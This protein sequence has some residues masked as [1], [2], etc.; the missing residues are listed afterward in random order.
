MTKENPILDATSF[1]KRIIIIPSKIADKGTVFLR[2]TLHSL[3]P[4]P[5][6]VTFMPVSMGGDDLGE[7]LARRKYS[8]NPI[9]MSHTGPNATY[10]A[11]AYCKTP[12][13]YEKMLL[14][15]NRIKPVVVV[16]GVIESQGTAKGI[17]KEVTTKIA[18]I[19]IERKTSYPVPN[20]FFLALILKIAEGEQIDIPNMKGAFWVWK[21]IWVN[22]RGPDLDE[23]GRNETDV[24]GIISP[25]ATTI[26]VKPYYKQLF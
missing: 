3:W 24:K 23:K 12:P 10:L 17:I 20:F 7:R 11:E 5:N 16:D 4:D 13:D 19:N 14:S 26:P 15:G 1:D 21:D 2:N 18:Q 8:A 6:L 25:H 9:H 22:G